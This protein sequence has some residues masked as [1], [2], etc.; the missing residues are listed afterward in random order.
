[1]AVPPLP[2]PRLGPGPGVGV[3]VDRVSA[4]V[5]RAA[6]PRV[7]VDPKRLA[8]LPAPPRGLQPRR[9]ALHRERPARDIGEQAAAAVELT[10]CGD[11]GGQRVLAPRLGVMT[12]EVELRWL[13][14]VRAMLPKG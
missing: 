11:G 12:R 4:V 9:H 5:A 10:Q 3:H 8:P 2:M 7:A 6:A 13:G 1:M 14:Q